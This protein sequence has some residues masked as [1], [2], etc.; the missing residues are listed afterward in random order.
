MRFGN[1]GG[2]IE[3]QAKASAC[4]GFCALLERLEQRPAQV[5]RD[6]GAVVHYRQDEFVFAFVALYDDRRALLT[7]SERVTHERVG[8]SAG[9][10]TSVA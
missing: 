6:F 8:R 4:V 3:T 9:H 5:H 7:M 10:R 1:R 2:D